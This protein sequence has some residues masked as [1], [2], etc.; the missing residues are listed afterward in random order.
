M[1]TER[2]KILSELLPDVLEQ[3]D[4]LPNGVKQW[5]TIIK[6]IDP[7]TEE[8]KIWC[9]PFVSGINQKDAELYCQNNGLGYCQVDGELI[10]EIPCRKGL[11]DP[12]FDN[13][14]SYE[15]LN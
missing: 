10:A 3:W 5:T 1:K 2:E 12:D 7:L 13:M 9:G 8:L 14:I 15:N 4:D 6:A 11:F